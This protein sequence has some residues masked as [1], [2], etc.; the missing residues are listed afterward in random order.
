MKK[1]RL[2][3]TIIACAVMIG[4]NII[5]S[6]NKNENASILNLNDLELFTTANA[7]EGWANGYDFVYNGNCYICYPYNW[8]SCP[9]SL[10]CCLFEPP[11]C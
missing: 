3:F 10:Q 1:M 9:V 6:T 7:E 4:T 2:V 11:Y 8:E 5:I